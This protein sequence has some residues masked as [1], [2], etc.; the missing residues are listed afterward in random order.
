MTPP[1]FRSD[2]AEHP[3]LLI[4]EVDDWG[5]RALDLLRP[6]SRFWA[7][8][9][10]QP[11]AWRSAVDAAR[12]TQEPTPIEL[13][14]TLPA[15]DTW[16]AMTRRTIRR[17]SAWFLVA[18]D[19]Q[20]RLD[21]QS[22][23]TLAHQASLVQHV[24]QEPHL[25]SVLI[26]DE[27]GLGKTIEAALIVK[28][29]LAQQPDL[30]IL[31]LAPARLVS[32]VRRE[33]ERLELPFRSWVAD[34]ARD[35]RLEDPLV[36]ASI[37]RAVV[38]AHFDNMIAQSRWD[39]L[40]VDE[41]HHLSAWAPHGGSAV[42]KY[43]LVNELRDRLKPSARVILLSGTPHQ[44]HAERFQNLLRLL[45]RGDEPVD[46]VAGRVIYRTKE[47]VRDWDGRPLFPL[48]QVN[49][50]LVH[51][52][53]PAHRKWLERIHDFFQP[54]AEGDDSER[55]A[56]GWRCGQALQWATSSIEA[57]LGYLV[58][59]AIRA[60]WTTRRRVLADALA[61]LRPYRNGAIDEAIDTL[62]DR[63]SREIRVQQ[64]AGTVE[65]LED[66]DDE[67]NPPV[68]DAR[69]AE[70]L[71]LGIALLA[72][73]RDAKWRALTPILDSA[74]TE[75]VVLFAQPIETVMALASFLQ[76][77]TGRRPAMI[78]GGQSEAERDAEVAAFW[79][80]DGPQYLVSSRAGGEGLNLQVARRLVHV[81]V[82]WNPM[83]MEQRVGRVHRFMSR[84]TIIV[85]TLVVKDSREA[86][87]YEVA[88]QKLR[89]VASSLAVDDAR[90]EALFARVMALVPPEELQSVLAEGGTGPL[91]SDHR[92]AV[93][94]LVTRGF[95]SWQGFHEQFA[96][97]QQEIRA[98]SAGLATWADLA[99][100]ARAH[101]GAVDADGLHAM[102]F[103]HIDGEVRD[104]TVEAT[105]LRIGD[106]VYSVGDHGG[107]PVIGPDGQVAPQLGLNAPA[108]QRALRAAAFTEEAVGAAHVRWQ[109][110]HA[111]LPQLDVPL[112]IAAYIRVPFRNIDGTIH[113]LPAEL[114]VSIAT[115]GSP[116]R[117]LDGVDKGAVI[118][119]LLSASVRREP[120]HAPALIDAL[121]RYFKESVAAARRP[122]DAERARDIRATVL[123]LAAVIVS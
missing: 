22:I 81:D 21:A 108:V 65:D 56:G 3:W 54:A 110:G 61:A 14:H 51:D 47:D 121:D 101:L 115:E 77:R 59:Q 58:R 34:P 20:R 29:L 38:P 84:R 52:L 55:R 25:Q 111:P 46:A 63:I 39:V 18:E 33:M 11:P 71:E 100:F 7:D 6:P 10:H 57:G 76:R 89:E 24:L 62:F 19:P 114:R 17:L 40:V 44:G 106:A 103:E 4:R 64:E 73:D 97:R 112:A 41:C 102:R 60:G 93:A 96:A 35:G 13:L 120:A 5:I 118:R 1:V 80:L 72:A 37:H 87:M 79:N 26:A 67:D 43:K 98:L 94:N 8:E 86:D 50:P 23:A 90:F 105:A 12:V 16:A 122:T 85:D 28:Q 48:R 74:G 42:R 91:S 30:R 88:R 2:D 92:R 83:E 69:L 107:M 75:K 31:Y 32:N 113:E 68:D 36:I 104:V 99:A 82:P 49:R 119:A 117:E 9:K 66:L 70:V 109:D 123:P 15:G 95:S 116:F 53:G 78:I 45:R 27:V